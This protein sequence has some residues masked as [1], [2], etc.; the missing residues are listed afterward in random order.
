MSHG[1]RFRMLRSW[2]IY[3]AQYIRE[4]HILSVSLLQYCT[5][6]NKCYCESGWSGSDCSIAVAVTT[7]Y[8]MPTPPPDATKTVGNLADI[9]KKKET[10]YGMY[11]L[12]QHQST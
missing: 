4:R 12:K 10:P 8:P 5:N 9:M 1:K 3:T 11:V 6:E 2:G 7:T